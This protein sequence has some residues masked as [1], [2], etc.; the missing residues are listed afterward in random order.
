MQAHAGV[1]GM[2]PALFPEWLMLFVA[3]LSEIAPT[4]EA[5]N[6]LMA[7]AERIARSMSLSLFYNPA[8]DD[9]AKKPA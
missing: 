3:T 8:L 1:E 4:E 5:G 2:K 7:T 6:R 9:P